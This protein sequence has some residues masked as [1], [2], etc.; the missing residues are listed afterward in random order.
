M[1][2]LSFHFISFL[3]LATRLPS[4]S[5]TK[6]FVSISQKPT[7]LM[8]THN[9][10]IMFILW[11]ILLMSTIQTINP[12]SATMFC[13]YLLRML[14]K[15]NDHLIL[16]R[17]HIQITALIHVYDCNKRGKSRVRRLYLLAEDEIFLFLL[18]QAG[19]EEAYSRRKTESVIIAVSLV[20]TMWEK[21]LALLFE[22][23]GESGE[24]GGLTLLYYAAW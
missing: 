21:F 10:H 7:R 22:E 16:D 2:N 8:S 4:T 5:L 9:Q 18:L 3:L 6:D 11:I 19:L 12:M 15:R 20:A 17:L 24:S 1:K 23:R 14:R 13:F